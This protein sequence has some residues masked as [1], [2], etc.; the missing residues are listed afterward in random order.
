MVEDGVFPGYQ[1][2][3][4]SAD[5]TYRFYG[6][7]SQIYPNKKPMEMG[8][9]FDL[10]SVTKVVGTV[11]ACLFLIE[12]GKLDLDM[13]VSD[14]FQGFEERVKIHH[15]LTHTSGLEADLSWRNKDKQAMRK[16][17]LSAKVREDYFEKV[18]VY[19]DIG[20]LILGF[21]INK[22]T[23]DLEN[24]LKEKLFIPL[25]MKNTFY[26]PMDKESC[27]P[28]ELTSWRGLV[29]GEVHDEKSFILGGVTGHAGLFSN[30]D[31]LLNYG[32]MLLAGGNFK[33]K[34]IL[35]SGS[36]ELLRKPLVSIGGQQRSLGWLISTPTKPYCEMLAHGSLFH[37]GFTGPSIL[38][39]FE[40]KKACLLLT[41]RVHPGRDNELLSKSRRLLHNRVFSLL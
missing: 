1:L 27:V 9:I 2:G 8:L 35:S 31:D 26:N 3:V 17:I 39:N 6:G 5:E 20:F 40:E 34:K 18:M 23:G 37:A 22:L 28:T 32:S 41:N 38:L 7:Y 13:S 12:E 24:Y 14:F 33:G 11:S 16:A 19:S 15:L 30:L 25:E 21:I 36:I 29:H 10:A 4:I